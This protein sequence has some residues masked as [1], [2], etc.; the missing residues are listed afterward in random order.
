MAQY[1]L[2]L[3]DYWRILHKR[4]MIVIFATILM[5]VFSTF[6]AVLQTPV[7]SYEASSSVKIE[8][9]STLTGLYVETLSWSSADNLETQAIIIKSY[10][11][12]EEVAKKLGFLDSNLTSDEIRRDTKYLNVVLKLK[13]QVETKREGF[14]NLVNIIATSEDPKLAQKLANTVAEVYRDQNTKERNKRIIEGRVFIEQQLELAKENLKEA[15][16]KVKEYREENKFISIDSETGTTLSQLTSIETEHEGLKRTIE[17]IN[18]ILKRIKREEAIPGKDIKGIYAD[19]VGPIFARLNSQLVDLTLERDTLL[20]NFTKNH[21]RLKEV[22]TKISETI[23]NMIAELSD[24]KKTFEGRKSNL[25][26]DLDRLRSKFRALP[27]KGLM[28][29][30]LEHDL[31]VKSQTFSL[32]E[33]KY[34]E[35]L[36]KEAEKVEEVSIVKPAVEP[37]SP[38][39]SPHVYTTSFIGVI[40][41]LIIGL[42]MAFVFETLDTS[43]GTIE[44]VEK[45]LEV[46]VLGVIP[47]VGDEDIKSIMLSEGYPENTD[48]EII[49]RNARLITHFAPNSTLAE[50]YKK[51]RTNVH[52]MRMEKDIKT[53]LYTSSSPFEGKTTTVINLAIAMAQ[54]SEKVLLIEADLRKPMV[55]K[56]F[57]IDKIPGL[58][59]IILGNY[60]WRDTVRTITDFITG[61][62]KID[63]IMKTPGIDNLNIITSG[64]ISPNPSEL[65]G[66]QRMEDFISQVREE[67][68]VVLFDSCPVLAAADASILA[69]KLDGAILVYHVGKI[70][71]GALR[72]AK[73]QLE[74]VKARVIGVVLNKLQT[75]ISPDYTEFKYDRYYAYGE[76][77]KTPSKPKRW[78]RRSKEK[79]EI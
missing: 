38:V 39:N 31:T 9:S 23:Q 36:I 28:L 34:Q 13:D 42:I 52:F 4:K 59:D 12:I 67:Y 8:R 56:L 79:L 47:H 14:T 2:T 21:P 30:R 62:M 69:S 50:S 61:D 49:R 58:S 65:L 6:F 72:R 55:S 41:G 66:S 46:P 74:N 76:K 75:E 16:E 17:E 57:G 1:D 43:I 68:D 29:A 24:Q 7:P 54:T 32:L 26:G 33:S 10:P 60:E 71:R 27:E 53:I 5:G 22:K 35:A 3:R 15:E 19:K 77:G 25:A 20:L 37:T 64:T 11:V 18:S 78:Y 70:A 63:D 44:D 73:A 51:L 45:F 40:I 48:E